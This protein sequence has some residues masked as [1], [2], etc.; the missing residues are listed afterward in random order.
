MDKATRTVSI[1]IDEVQ[2]KAQLANAQKQAKKFEDQ[3][4]NLDMGSKE[5]KK[6]E[7]ELAKW[8]ARLKNIQGQLDGSITPSVRQLMD[9]QR[10]LN[11]VLNEMPIALRNASKEAKQLK[12][13]EEALAKVRKEAKESGSSLG[14]IKDNIKG[15]ADSFNKY[16]GMFTAFIGALFG[17]TLSFEQCIEVFM[18]FENELKNL[19]ALTGLVGRELT[20]LGN[21]AM[22]MSTSIAKSGGRITQS[23]TEILKAFT[24]MGSKKPELLENKDAL[25]ETT[26]EA[27]IL[28][29]AAKMQV[30]PAVESLANTMNQFNADAKEAP[31][32]INALAAGSKAGAAEVDSINASIT[33]FGPAAA[34]A[35]ISIE[36]SVGL[37]ETLAEKGVNA[38]IAGTGVRNVILKLMQGAD[39]FNPR[40][41]GMNK[42]LE[43]LKNQ[44]LSAAQMVE[45]F[46]QENY[47]VAQILVSNTDK[48][49]SYTEAVTGT[50]VAYEQHAINTDTASAKLKQQRNEIENNSIALGE[51][52]VPMKL[53]ASQATL[54]FIKV[55]VQLP[56]FLKE[57]RSLITSLGAAIL[58]YYQ[59]LI[60]TT[61]ATI[62][63]RIA[64]M[65]SAAAMNTMRTVTLA[66]T[67]VS[68]KMTGETMRAAAAQKLL[69][70]TFKM[71]PFGWAI[72]VIG[73]LVVALQKFET[74]TGRAQKLEAQK[75]DARTFLINATKALESAEKDLQKQSENLA[76]L[77]LQEKQRLQER[78]ELTIKNTEAEIAAIQVKMRA[79]AL[80]NTQATAWQTVVNGVKNIGNTYGF[81]SDQVGSAVQNSVDATTEFSD[82]IANLEDKLNSIKG[83]STELGKTLNA[84]RDADAIRAENIN[85]L[86]E[87]LRKYNI[88]L[89][90]VKLGTED[91]DRVARKIAATEKQLAAARPTYVPAEEQKK[92]DSKRKQAT[93]HYKDLHDDAVSFQAQRLN[94]QMQADAKE[95]AEEQRKFDD[96]IKKLQDFLKEEGKL[97][98]SRDRQNILRDIG[99]LQTDKQKAVNA[100]LIRQQEE[101]S[102]K[103]IALREA[104]R[105]ENMAAEQKEI[106][107]FRQKIDEQLRLVKGN[108]D[109]TA[110]LE[111]VLQEGITAIQQKH[112]QNRA[113][114]AAEIRREINDIGLSERQKEI[115]DIDNRYDKLLEEA[116]GNEELIA[117]I[118]KAKIDEIAEY[119]R[120]KNIEVAQLL[121]TESQKVYDQ[122]AQIQQ[123]KRQQNLNEQVSALEAQRDA[124]LNNTANSEAQKKAIEDKYNAQIKD[125]KRKDWE[126]GKKAAKNQA[127]I[128]GALAITNILATRPKFDLGIGDAIMIGAAIAT[129][130][131]Q[132]KAIDEQPVPEFG[133]G[134]DPFNRKGG[135][136]DG[137]RHTAGGIKM[138]RSDNGKVVG[139]MEGGEPWMILSRNTYK[140]NKPVVD[141]LLRASL[142]R[143]GESIMSSWM[144][145]QPARINYSRL[146]GPAVRFANG[147]F[148]EI[149]TIQSGGSGQV[150]ASVPVAQLSPEIA[151]IL[152]QLN[153]TLAQLYDRLGQPIMAYTII[154]DQQADAIVYL[155]NNV[156]QSRQNAGV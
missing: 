76:E 114:K 51:R 106:N 156:E 48:V 136:P 60:R 19:S 125:L 61:A 14:R 117:E 1:I 140:N 2:L 56:A 11:K 47:T 55:L 37:I 16:L 59:N 77:S 96:R 10:R 72:A 145:E 141:E 144:Y 126:A 92:L 133:R 142:Y 26:E 132:V 107:E 131:A 116:I 40:L 105:E 13:V 113:K 123:N 21:Q 67:V 103:V 66:Y 70:Q 87:K 102:Q 100:I 154:D 35:N 8:Q 3:L 98:S 134:R 15:F 62:A 4:K 129:T 93:D 54:G 147:G 79:I 41:V 128:N 115:K 5:Y 152:K 90:T 82:S 118:K 137:P 6:A 34:Q 151:G 101:F 95:L 65:A 148:G 32:Y 146:T 28:A 9:E 83:A 63:N 109:R 124:E 22:E 104:V 139:E 127:I 38:E 89:K 85:Q 149:P 50:N 53:L 122:I 99:N 88:A 119:Q 80:E 31:R 7:A 58:I 71:T 43:N 42:A 120:G 143:N 78:Y 12:A 121:L 94:D 155:A 97:L 17:V 138:I 24:L 20:W 91:Y 36:E 153:I 75:A 150:N 86:E 46:G 52:F 110:E 111:E 84:E 108:A 33:K 23:S 73:A 49:K 18:A 74:I 81:L 130:A 69:G 27:L 39:Q 135:I 44:N 29:G 45:L 64:T 68:S 30:E 25:K 112:A 57:N